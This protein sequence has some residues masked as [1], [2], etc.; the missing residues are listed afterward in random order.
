MNR[1]SF[2]LGSA[3]GAAALVVAALPAHA[4]EPKKDES[5]KKDDSKDAGK[6]KDEDK[7]AGDPARPTEPEFLEEHTGPDGRK[8]R[9]CP[10][11]G[12]NMYRQNRT[13]TCENCGFTY[14]E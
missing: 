9:M 12:Y 4:Q 1:R 3:L 2:L 7:K 8:F 11:C 6:S 5:S 14:D 13:W 10:V